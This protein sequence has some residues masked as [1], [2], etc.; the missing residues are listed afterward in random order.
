MLFSCSVT[1]GSYLC[2][3]CQDVA[4]SSLV[5]LDVGTPSTKVTATADR[6]SHPT[7]TCLQTIVSLRLIFISLSFEE[8]SF[9]VGN[10]FLS[11]S[12]YSFVLLSLLSIFSLV[13][14]F[15]LN[16]NKSKRCSN[17]LNSYFLNEVRCS[18][19]FG[20]SNSNSL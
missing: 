7:H 16:R 1:C 3:L 20:C 14:I 9:S 4:L 12:F 18:Y 11:V 13:L 6:A 17:I 2:F 8:T 5:L 15:F 10:D 19:P